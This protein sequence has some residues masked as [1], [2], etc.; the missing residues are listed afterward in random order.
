MQC[1]N[2]IKREILVEKSILNFKAFI[3]NILLVK[4]KLCTVFEYSL[5]LGL[6]GQNSFIYLTGFLNNKL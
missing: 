5:F 6:K 4:L 1:I 2:C 3:T